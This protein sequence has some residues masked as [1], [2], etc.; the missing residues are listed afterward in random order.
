M[1][2]PA[3]ILKM[4]DELDA[5]VQTDGLLTQS[6]LTKLAEVQSWYIDYLDSLEPLPDPWHL[7]EAMVDDIVRRMNT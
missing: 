7:T 1:N 4:I 3:N 2:V 6:D 5:K